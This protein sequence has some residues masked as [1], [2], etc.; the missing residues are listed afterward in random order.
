MLSDTEF[1]A[2]LYETRKRHPDIILPEIIAL[3][4]A[5]VEQARIDTEVGERALRSKRWKPTK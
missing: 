4:E 5:R 1:L 3:Y 2:W